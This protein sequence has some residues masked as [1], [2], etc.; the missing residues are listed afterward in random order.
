MQGDGNIVRGGRWGR[1][2]ALRPAHLT[3]NIDVALL[4]GG[5]SSPRRTVQF[6][7]REVQR[8]RLVVWYRWKTALHRG[9]VMRYFE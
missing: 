5:A 6:V 7:Q 4:Y 2:S 3:Q 8:I 1:K 9:E